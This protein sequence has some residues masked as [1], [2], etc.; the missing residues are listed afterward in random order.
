MIKARFSRAVAPGRRRASHVKRRER[1]VWQRRFW[2]RHVRNEEEMAAC[3]RY[4]HFNP[5][6]HGFVARPQDWP[7]SSVHRDI[8]AGRWP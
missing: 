2:E 1:G 3:I 7:F 4:C 5:V 8:R 6:K